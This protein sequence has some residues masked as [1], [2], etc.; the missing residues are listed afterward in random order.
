MGRN[1]ELELEVGGG[2]DFKHYWLVALEVSPGLHFPSHLTAII[3][4]APTMCR[5]GDYF[6]HLFS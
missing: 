1:G 2:R 3:N 6:R 5:Q 4:Q